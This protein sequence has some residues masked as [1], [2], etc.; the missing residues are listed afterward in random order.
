MSTAAPS[1]APLG[2][3]IRTPY[4]LDDSDRPAGLPPL[5]GEVEA[6]LVVVGGGYTGLWTALS[7]LERDPGRSVVVL[8]AAGC[9]HAASGRNGG[10]VE[11]S[12][13]HGFGNGLARWP[14][15]TA[16]LLRLAQENLDG[17]A[18]VV[19]RHGIDCGFERS[20]SLHVATQPYQV[21]ELREAAA[22]Q[23]QHGAPVQWLDS[24]QL[25]ERVRS[26]TYLT[27][28]YD[29]QTALVEPARLAWGL[30]EACR[31]LGAVVHEGSP[32]SRLRRDGA[33]VR[34]D[35]PAGSVLAGRAVLATNA[36]PPLLRRLRLLTVPVY[37]Y[38]LVTE[39]LDARQR[40]AIGWAG[41]EGIGDSGN[42]FHYYRQTRDHRILF[43]GYDAI[44]HY[45][46]AM[47]PAHEHRPATYELLA[48]HLVATFPAL[49][50][51]GVSHSWG[52]VID[53]STRFCAFH[54]TAMGGRVAYALGFTGLGVAATRFAAD[55]MLDLLAGTDSER[56]RLAMVRERPVPF[57]PEPV[58]WAGV[59]ATRWSL[60]RADR[61]E[62]R[63]NLWLKMTDSL[64]LGFDS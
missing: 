5:E 49:E 46:S 6:D 40:D 48:R 10:F 23:E 18:D 56:T 26:P 44:Y 52:G 53:T 39:P 38:A 14:Q 58:R 61:H 30:R 42:Q 32:A 11:P 47:G 35:T 43:G 41:R 20:G 54:G 50:G 57:P 25:S 4:W 7:A 9:G 34:V 36:Y 55:V 60:A 27:A 24:E 28:T 19:H 31:R 37:D 64:G 2:T 17:I 62:G 13:T 12:L 45:G 8:E 29:P 51:I 22:A 21:A 16:T 15:D 59:Q 1:T 63:R 33:G 3:A